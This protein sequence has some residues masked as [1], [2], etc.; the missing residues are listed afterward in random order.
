M[1]R[2][3][4]VAVDSHPPTLISSHLDVTVH[5]I[6]DRGELGSEKEDV[7]PAEGGYLVDSLGHNVLERTGVDVGHHITVNV[8]RSASLLGLVE[9]CLT[10]TAGKQR[11]MLGV[12]T[13]ETEGSRSGSSLGSARPSRA[14]RTGRRW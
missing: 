2:R 14:S 7:D 3:E 9:E 13:P 5:T 8:D 11:S 10:K 1:F 4:N 6:H 12:Y